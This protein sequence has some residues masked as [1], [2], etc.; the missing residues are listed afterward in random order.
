[1]RTFSP[2]LRQALAA[3]LAFLAQYGGGILLAGGS[4]AAGKV[5]AIVRSLFAAANA[6]STGEAW[7]SLSDVLPLLAEASPEAF[8]EAVSTGLSGNDPPLSHPFASDDGGV[9]G[10]SSHAGLLWALEALASSPRH[11]GAAADAF[12]R[13]DEI[14]P[15]GK[16]GKRPMTSLETVFS[17]YAPQTSTNSQGRLAVIDGLRTR[18]P[19]VAWKLLLSMLPDAHSV[20]FPTHEPEIR[21]WKSDPAPVSRAAFFDVVSAV[22][23]RCIADAGQTPQRWTQLLGEL[24]HLPAADREVVFVAL[25]ALVDSD[26]GFDTGHLVWKAARDIGWDA[27]GVRQFF[28]GTG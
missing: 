25:E 21:D 20:I 18:H 22:V 16:R 14:D 19:A 24:Q 27:S 13:L 23:N 12:A 15:R 3:T 26:A 9:F 11:F 5:N 17:P 7:V 2:G 1:V 6:D 4:S 28:V 8:L 10:H